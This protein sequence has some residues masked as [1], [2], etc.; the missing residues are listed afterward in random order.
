M[1]SFG[2]GPASIV[3][4][5]HG[6]LPEEVTDPIEGTWYLDGVDRERKIASYRLKT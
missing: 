4:E 3:Y 5:V 6:V 2:T 1:P